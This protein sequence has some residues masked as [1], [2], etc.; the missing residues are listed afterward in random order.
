[1]LKFVSHLQFLSFASRKLGPPCR[2]PLLCLSVWQGAS[3]ATEDGERERREGKGGEERAGG[4]QRGAGGRDLTP[5]PN[6]SGA[7]RAKNEVDAAPSNPAL[8]G[9][10][11]SGV[12]V[13]VCWLALDTEYL[14]FLTVQLAPRL[15][16]SMWN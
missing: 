7:N 4:G 13:R 11:Q 5:A 9:A 15:F 10:Q 12:V 1:M 2:W 8:R 6:P 14:S 3:R 16:E